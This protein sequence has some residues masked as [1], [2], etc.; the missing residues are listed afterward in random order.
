M[1][2]VSV[3]LEVGLPKYVSLLAWPP[4][5][6]TLVQLPETKNG[7]KDDSVC[8]DMLEDVLNCTFAC[9]LRKQ[10]SGPSKQS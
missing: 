8:K 4:I 7:W 2:H 9:S 10:R 3:Y 5:S 6:S 1:N